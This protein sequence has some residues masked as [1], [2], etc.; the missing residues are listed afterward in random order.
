M[1][2]STDKDEVAPT[3]AK[4]EFIDKDRNIINASHHGIMMEDSS[5]KK[6]DFILW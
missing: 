6:P 3:Y 1:Y 2:N 4:S 5:S